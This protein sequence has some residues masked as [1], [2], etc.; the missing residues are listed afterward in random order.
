MSPPILNFYL[1][2]NFSWSILT[3]DALIWVFLLHLW[4]NPGGWTSALASHIL[5]LLTGFASRIAQYVAPSISPLALRSLWVTAEDIHPCFQ[6]AFSTKSHVLSVTVTCKKS[7]VL[8]SHMYRDYF[9]IYFNIIT[10]EFIYF[11][12]PWLFFS[13]I[14]TL[15]SCNV[16]EGAL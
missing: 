3:D 16:E 7:E 10:R 12:H 6:W 15:L 8:H 5:Q 1:A 4:L 9:F 14:F 13:F 11:M 2:L